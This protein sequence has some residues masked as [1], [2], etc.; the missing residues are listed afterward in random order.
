MSPL[1]AAW[2]ARNQLA[3]WPCME[4]VAG[5]WPVEVLEGLDEGVAAELS[6]F[7]TIDVSSELGVLL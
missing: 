5:N 2:S 7:T 3:A 4:P 1:L 6:I